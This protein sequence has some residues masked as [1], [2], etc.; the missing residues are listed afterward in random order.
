MDKEEFVNS[1]MKLSKEDIIADYYETEE[2][3]IKKKK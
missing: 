1:K 2:E 3:L